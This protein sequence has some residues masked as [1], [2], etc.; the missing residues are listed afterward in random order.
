[1]ASGLNQALPP[2]P[3]DGVQKLWFKRISSE[4]DMVVPCKESLMKWF[5][6]DQERIFRPILDEMQSLDLTG[7]TIIDS[8]CPLSPL[9]CI[10]LIVLFDQTP[11]NIYRQAESSVV[12]TV[13]DPIAHYI[14]EAAIAS[15]VHRHP[16][17]KY[18][19]GH[20]QW[21]IMPFMHSESLE[22]YKKAVRLVQEM[23]EDVKAVGVSELQISDEHVQADDELKCKL[24]IAAN[25]EA[26]IQL[27]ESQVQFELKHKDIIDRFGRYP[28]RNVPLGRNMTKDEQEFL[29]SGGD[30][31][32][33]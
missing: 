10:S 15:G 12:F 16:S 23:V 25:K 33:G 4:E 28:H 17:V 2:M 6:R 29:D 3:I 20:R 30:T 24:M 32:S 5:K 8:L 14:A 9:Q 26:A 27:C 18:R 31:F 11:R 19:I 22:E 1:M 21:I 7:Q 13:F